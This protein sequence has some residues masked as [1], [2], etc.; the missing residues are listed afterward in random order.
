MK[1]LA[2]AALIST[3]ALG[4][5]L[6]AQSPSPTRNEFPLFVRVQLD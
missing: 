4:S 2:L 6:R 5:A 3:L 1:T